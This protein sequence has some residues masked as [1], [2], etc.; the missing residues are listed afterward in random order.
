[1][2]SLEKRVRHLLPEKRRKENHCLIET[3]LMFARCRDRWL[4]I[5]D[6]L[7]LTR[8]SGKPF[9]RS[10]MYLVVEDLSKPMVA[11]GGNSYV[12][13]EPIGTGSGRPKKYRLSKAAHERIYSLV[14]P[15]QIQPEPVLHHL[16]G[17]GRIKIPPLPLENELE[18]KGL[19]CKKTEW[20]PANDIIDL[21]EDK[22]GPSDAN[23]SLK[24]ITSEQGISQP[25]PYAQKCEA[26]TKTHRW[27]RPP[28][29]QFELTNDGLIYHLADHNE[30]V[31]SVDTIIVDSRHDD[32][33]VHA[34]EERARKGE[35]EAIG[36]LIR[37]LFHDSSKY[38]RQE[39]ARSLGILGDACSIDPLIKAMLNDEYSGVRGVAAEGLGNFGY[40]EEFAA[41][42]KDSNSHIRVVVASILGK[43]KDE[44]AIGPLTESLRDLDIGVQCGAALAL[45]DIG[46]TRAIASLTPLLECENESLRRAACAALGN[47]KD[48]QAVPALKRACKDP[49]AEVRY[50]AEKAL[51]KLK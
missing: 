45:G 10:A 50:E 11:L 51:S 39:A 23:R 36:E 8:G 9:S 27:G 46:S 14:K 42:L 29:E 35:R 16:K 4:T 26:V 32:E 12:D 47:V 38:A 31:V 1:M 17:R 41:A 2:A 44:R 5:G 21:V 33:R 18:M 48:P 20:L 37:V 34:L 6:L 22:I 7:N 49:N 40:C 30:L 13:C 24:I 28:K 3:A 15:L 25:K 19:R 43:M